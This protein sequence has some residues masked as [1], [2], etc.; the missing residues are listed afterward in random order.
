MRV[1]YW[2]EDSSTDIA[3]GLAK[4]CRACDT[5]MSL[6]NFH[7]DKTAKD[8]HLARCKKCR[9]DGILIPGTRFNPA[10]G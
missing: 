7:R 2:V 8:G 3:L 10:I 5:L 1:F 6:D 4:T 9:M